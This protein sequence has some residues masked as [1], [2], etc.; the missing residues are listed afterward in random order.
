MEDLH[1]ANRRVW[2]QAAGNY[3]QDLK[4]S[5]DVLQSGRADLEPAELEALKSLIG[6]G[7]VAV[8]LQCAAGHDSLALLNMGI[9]KVVGVD[10]SEEM[11][12]IAKV[13]SDTLGANAEWI[14][15]D[16]L[17]LPETLND[18]AD[19]VYT[20]KGAINWIMDLKKWARVVARIL[21]PGGHLFL[22]E[23]H[24]ITYLFDTR[25]PT[26]CIAPEFKGYFAGTVY[27]NQGWTEEYV[28]S[29]GLSPADHHTK[30]ERAGPVSEVISE[31]LDTGLVL[32][33]FREYA[34][35]Y[36]AEFPHMPAEERSKLPN[37]Y[38]VTL[39]K[40]LAAS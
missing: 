10:I 16:I 11:L 6:S 27:A 7:T 36:W 29:L 9:R 23:G 5:I 20:G 13:K 17:S 33:G 3:K 19:L 39:K 2:N 30:H 22:F 14:R 35:P 1:E 8:H 40:P 12:A 32:A 34:D 4:E 21:K 15:S 18:A 38:S 31:L 24:P 28:G 37:T 26:L 25:T